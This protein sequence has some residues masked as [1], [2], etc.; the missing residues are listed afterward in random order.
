MR[1]FQPSPTILLLADLYLAI[2]GG[3]HLDY[4][5]LHSTLN[6]VGI[7]TFLDVSITVPVLIEPNLRFQDHCSRISMGHINNYSVQRTETTTISE[8]AFLP[9]TTTV[10]AIYYTSYLTL[11]FATANPQR[12]VTTIKPSPRT[13][14]SSEY[15]LCWSNDPKTGCKI[16]LG[17][18][19]VADLVLNICPLGIQNNGGLSKPGA[20]TVAYNPGPCFKTDSPYLFAA[21]FN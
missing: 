18:T 12:P 15:C 16:V 20:T 10:P 17:T 9:A 14:T 5:L 8:S 19:K 4:L 2:S 3:M 11:N 21:P 13:S 7:A 6:T 1:S